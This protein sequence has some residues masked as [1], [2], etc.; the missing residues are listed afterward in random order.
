MKVRRLDISGFKS[1][2]DRTVMDFPQGLSAVVGPNGCGKSNVVDAM[3]WV[4]GE[5][6]ARQL[7]GQNMEDVIFNGADSRKASG[8]AEVSV[9]FENDGSVSAAAYSGLSEIMVTRRLYRN[10]DSEYLINRMPC[11]LKDIQQLLMD[12]GL[13]NRA[14]AIIEQGRVAAF[15][16]AKPDE[17]RLWVEEAAGITRYKNQKKIS[18]RKMEATRDNLS[19]LE[20]ILLE[21]TTQMERLRRQAK[22]AERHKEIRDRIRELDLAIASFEYH[23]LSQ[24][25]DQTAAEEEAAAAGLEL[26]QQR[27]G[28]LETDLETARLELLQAEEEIRSSGARRLEAQ[29]AIQKAEN[30]LILMGREA[31]NLKRQSERLEQEREQLKAALTRSQQDL[32]R[33]QRV[34]AQSEARA[35]ESEQAVAQA[36]QRVSGQQERLTA[37]EQA[38]DQAKADLVDHMSL[39][40]QTRNRLGDLERQRAELERR[41]GQ[42][43]RQRAE[44]AQQ[45]SQAA[46]ELTQAQAKVND[47]R[48]RLEQ[49]AAQMTCL[50]A[51]RR[52]QQ[53]NLAAAR[54]QEEEAS[55]RRFDLAAQVDALGASLGSLAWAGAAVRQ[56]LQAAQEGSLPVPLV[57]VVAEKLNVQPGREEL[58]ETALGPDLQALIVKTG[59]EALALAAWAGQEGLGRLRV[60]ALEELSARGLS[61]PDGARPLAELARPEPGCEP[62]AHLLAGAGWCADLEE[63]WR[64]GAGLRPGQSLVSPGGQRLD[65]PGLATVGRAEDG[66]SVL[67]GRNELNRLRQ[68]LSAAEGLVEQAGGRRQQ[69]QQE[70]SACEQEQAALA[71]GHQ[72]L[73][74]ELAQAERELVRHQE[75]TQAAGR[76]LEALEFEAGE[77]AD[78]QAQVIADVQQLRGR[79]EELQGRDQSL[80]ERLETARQAL[81]LARTD[82]EQAR[83]DE[84]EVKL[85]AAA[86]ASEAAQ[87]QREA[88]RLRAE[89]DR[90]AARVLALGREIEQAQTNLG[91]LTQ[92]R[93]GQQQGL[94][95]LYAE[96][97]R[98]ESDL[99][100]AQ[101]VLG[102]AQNQAQSLESEIKQARGELK[103]AEGVSQELAWNLKELGLRREQLCEQVQERCQVE[104]AAVFS[105]HLPSGPFDPVVGKEKLDSLRKRLQRLGPVNLEAISEHEALA[106][107][108]GF[109]SEQK[110]D[111]D[112]SLEDLKQAIRK[113]NRTS[114]SR[115]TETLEQ[116]NKRL[117]GVFAVLFGGGRAQL[118]LEEGVDPLDAGL[119]LMV[120]LPGKKVK[121]LDALSGGEKAMSAVAVLFALFLIRPA[122]FCILDEVD[123]PLDEANTGRFLDLLKQLARRSQILMITHNR[124]TME[125][126]E[127]LYGVTMEERGVSKLLAVTLE[128]GESM[129]A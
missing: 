68:E 53:E 129:A 36:G 103:R 92:R 46:G 74:H 83:A 16:E 109:L 84:G 61:E 126:M 73:A 23:Q 8:L 77:V 106:E 88:Q 99:K 82:L 101:A 114:R 35:R 124:S 21:V 89:M 102:Q 28:A 20:D 72:R 110:A 42:V 11:R 2:A 59:T 115:F 26:A 9:V 33:A 49:A 85:R 12:T 91:G 47:L 120:E 10:G 22:K 65:R 24:R 37:A 44:L 48:A 95:G 27:M 58:V 127:T 45:Q 50:A 98:Q 19:R 117:D 7:R 5:Q 79:L 15:I 128:Q 6:S 123:A 1:F 52:Q 29:G 104:L 87:A 60:V 57:G 111:L 108:H 63:A 121:N 116:V 70:Q 34:L 80:E 3:R 81:N 39:V 69:A 25:L 76:R 90:D 62:L 96:L 86:L 122:P 64:A 4:L 71:A 13:G 17:R 66:A 100:Q 54:R 40:S 78:Q 125:I 55:R 14:Y 51:R 93:D 43:E 119:H 38:V 75:Q 56:A 97:D 41:V 105:G 113:I 67:A 112:A 31:E 118:V 32:A 18:L 94:G 30:E 107:R